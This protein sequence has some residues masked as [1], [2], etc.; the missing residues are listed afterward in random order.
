VDWQPDAL[1]KAPYQQ[2]NRK[3]KQALIR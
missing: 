1:V 2:L 3:I